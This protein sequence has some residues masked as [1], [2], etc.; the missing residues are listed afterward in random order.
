MKKVII[1]AGPAGLYTAIS[2]KKAGAKDIVIYDPRAGNYTRPGHLNA[3]VFKKAEQ[4]TNTKFWSDEKGHIKDLERKLYIEAQKLGIPIEKKRFITLH[5]DKTTPGV[6]V[7]DE[8]GAEE[9]VPAKYVFD[10][11]GSQRHVI[12]AVNGIWPDSG[13]KL[14]QVTDTPIPHHFIAYVKMNETILESLAEF[15]SIAELVGYDSAISN[16]NAHDFA[17]SIVQLRALGWNELIFPR[18][19]GVP[20][21]KGKVCLY[22]QTPADLLSE[23]HD[24]WLQTVLECYVKPVSY[25]HLPPSRKYASKPRFTPFTVSANALQNTACKGHNL[26]TVI[27]LGDAQID[28]DYYLAHGILN[29]MV[30]IDALLDHIEI[31]NGEIEYFD[32]GDYQQ[33]IEKLLREHKTQVREQATKVKKQCVNALQPA[34]LKLQEALLTSDQRKLQEALIPI[35]N[36]INARLSYERGRQLF[37]DT[38]NASKQVVFTPTTINAVIANLTKIHVDLCTTWSGLPSSF[39]SQREETENLLNHLATSWKEIGSALFKDKKPAEAIHAYNKA[40]EI[41]ALPGFTNQFIAKELPLHSNLAIMYNAE[42]RYA[43]A[44]TAA[45]T[46]LKAYDRCPVQLQ[47]T[48]IREKIIFNLIKA[49]CAK[50]QELHQEKGHDEAIHA[51]HAQAAKLFATHAGVLV[52]ANHQQAAAMIDALTQQLPQP[53]ANEPL[54]EFPTGASVTTSAS[55]TQSSSAALQRFGSFAATNEA[56]DVASAF[57][58]DN[59]NAAL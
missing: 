7:A 55:L 11:T 9:I 23:N 59:Y 15:S 41:Y 51:C 20:F 48:A 57:S 40:L 50:G 22:L 16:I 47:P 4:G 17:Q 30:R 3:S 28:P 31:F 8:T 39:E 10:C 56:N 49:L 33:E 26:P 46:A 19:Y 12:N 24:K 29:G 14:N 13:L 27:A 42:K 34:K 44:I 43:E 25:E 45:Q 5:Q 18:C 38:H 37:S 1:G 54:A 35:L 53:P 36:E 58:L 6:I 2:L 52:T 32:S 21:G